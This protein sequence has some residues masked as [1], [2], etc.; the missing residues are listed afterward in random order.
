MRQN[1]PLRRHVSELGSTVERH[2]I[3]EAFTRAEPKNS[4]IS[5]R[6]HKCDGPI[7]ALLRVLDYP[8]PA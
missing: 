3:D 6:C 1:Q 7:L 8:C 4:R 2:P 5:K